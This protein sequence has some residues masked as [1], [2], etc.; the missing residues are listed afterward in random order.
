M[1]TFYKLMNYHQMIKRYLI[2]RKRYNTYKTSILTKEL[3]KTIMPTI[4]NCSV[5]I[6]SLKSF[7]SLNQ[8]MRLRQCLLYI[9]RNT[10]T[11]TVLPELQSIIFPAYGNVTPNLL[12]CSF[13]GK[14]GTAVNITVD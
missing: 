1:S 8:S 14:L 11:R 9:L 7:L 2:K 12:C 3:V 6:T 4:E 10:Y 5:I 13:T